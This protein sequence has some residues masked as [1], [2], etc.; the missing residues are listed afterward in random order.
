MCPGVQD[1]RFMLWILIRISERYYSVPVK[2]PNPLFKTGFRTSFPLIKIT[3]F[4]KLGILPVGKKA[5]EKVRLIVNS[6]SKWNFGDFLRLAV[7][8]KINSHKSYWA[9][10]R[11]Y[12]LNSPFLSSKQGFNWCELNRAKCT[13]RYVSRQFGCFSRNVGPVPFDF[14]LWRSIRCFEKKKYH[15]VFKA[16]TG[17]LW[18]K[19]IRNFDFSSCATNFPFG[20]IFVDIP[21]YCFAVDMTLWGRYNVFS[22]E[23]C[24][25][26]TRVTQP[27][28]QKLIL[29]N[30]KVNNDKTYSITVFEGIPLGTC[31]LPLQSTLYLVKLD[32]FPNEVH[33]QFV[34]LLLG[35]WPPSL[36]TINHSR[37]IKAN[38]F[39]QKYIFTDLWKIWNSS[40]TGRWSGVVHETNQK[41]RLERKERKGS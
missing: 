37:W 4:R 28:S 13:W 21:S 22:F 15:H 30:I 20:S 6:I 10:I 41:G 24:L 38:V 18:T 1:Y 36:D 7:T 14:F 9:Q 8:F 40:S 19:N 11:C 17:Y 29:T 3:I 12:H 33:L 25:E 5:L 16:T 23:V 34:G 27:W 2:S 31:S 35:H 26:N 39:K 32:I